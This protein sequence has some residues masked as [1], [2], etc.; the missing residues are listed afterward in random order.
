MKRIGLIIFV[1][2]IFNAVNAQQKKIY[3]AP[4]DHTD[5]MWTA[6]EERY[7]DAFLKTLDYYIKL[8]D[9]TANELY[10]YQSKW[11]CDG[12]LW[13]YEYQKNRSPQQF[14]TLIEQI[15]NEKITVPLNTIAAVHGIAP[16]EVTLRDMYFAGS[17]ERKY[18]L[19]LDLVINM[20]DQVLPLGLSSLW[21]GSGAKYSWRGVCA[22]ATKVK[23]FQNRTNEIY[24]YKGL[25]D[26]K[27]LMKWYSLYLNNRRL[28]GYAEAR[29]PKHSIELCKDLMTTNKYPYLIS[30]AFGKG[31][32]DYLTTTSEFIKA[33]KDYSDSDYQIIVSNEIDFFKDFEKEYGSVLPSE[34]ISYGS[35]E[36]G[37]SVASLAE[38]SATVKRSIEK[39]RSAEALYTLVAL[40]DKNFASELTE[41]REKA[42]I[43]C[44]LYFE[45]DWTA[46]G[47][48]ITRK[49]RADWQR[50]IANQL[51]SYVDT[52]YDLSM[53]RLGELVTK[54][55]KASDAFFVFNPL[56]WTRTDYSDY[57]YSG[58]SD[59]KVVDIITSQ[60]VPFQFITK[61]N[62]KYLRILAKEVPSL[63]Y[64]VYEI[65]KGTSS[66]RL[67]Q[68][69][70]V[71]DTIIENTHYKI[72]FIPQGVITSLV[73][74]ADNNHECINP[75]NKL[76]ANDLGFKRERAGSH[77][78]VVVKAV[79]VENAGPV[80][81]T[82]VA[83]YYKPIKHLSKLTLF[84]HN[85]RIELENYITQNFDAKPVTYSFSFNLSNLEVWHEEA[86]AILKAKP[87]SQ[88]GHYA[89]SICRLDWIAMN[90]FA[91]ISDGNNGMI[92]SNRDAFF[93]KTGNST[94]TTLDCVTPQ[95]NVLA[96]GQIDAP[97][98]GIV[99][100]DGD[101]YFENYFALKPNR[102]GFNAA[103]AMKFSLEHQNPLL[104]GKIT[105]KSG[106]YGSQFSLFT[107]SDPNVLVWALKPAEEG[108][109]DGIILR[110]WNMDNKNSDCTISSVFPIIKCKNT[111]HIETDESEIVPENGQ[112]KLKIG[113]N[114]LHTFRIYLK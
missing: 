40:K 73:D 96:G 107:V 1:A 19:N 94:V 104:S 46:D 10:P 47:R 41:M 34:T 48:Y 38:V 86:G 36:W 93:M 83:E 18:G 22:C 101:S 77:P 8:N 29:N 71:S 12:S 105:G 109:E 88:G 15:K 67:T 111:T 45:H 58:S 63:G 23:G 17:L 60:E 98:L 26:Q 49:H 65:T 51:C 68:A 57:P 114:Q 7:K 50:K 74:K 90:H 87:Q 78:G 64:K 66:A 11:N 81:V 92:L 13:V 4:D 59:I 21:A 35:T 100:Q 113:H 75:V 9:S 102:N 76:Y 110:V 20:E 112:L 103:T 69:A 85:D 37:I 30:G 16:L 108:I 61:N 52:L 42:W 80:S 28:G 31:E 24:W 99:N 89:D 6:D 62:V 14:A 53:S 95:I 25:D 106:S 82:L 43:A 84:G 32:D 5:Y 2:L 70:T 27:V 91:D 3:L 39:L 33:A 55:R 54:P 97:N 44:G 79:R 72:T 56:S